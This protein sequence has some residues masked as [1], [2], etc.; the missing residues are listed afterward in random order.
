MLFIDLPHSNRFIIRH[1]LAI[2][3]IISSTKQTQHQ[4]KI[5]V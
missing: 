1:I 2:F 3:Y 4:L 5:E